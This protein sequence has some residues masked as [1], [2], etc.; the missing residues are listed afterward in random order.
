MLHLHT[1]KFLAV[2]TH[3]IVFTLVQVQKDNEANAMT[4]TVLQEVEVGTNL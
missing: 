1:L 4:Q 3:D 2:Y